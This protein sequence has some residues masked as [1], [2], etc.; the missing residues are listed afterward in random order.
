MVFQLDMFINL[1]VIADLVTI[2]D[3]GQEIINKNLRCQNLKRREWDYA[4]GQEVLIKEVDPSKLQ[5]RA[6]GPYTV[7]HVFA[8]GTVNVQRAPH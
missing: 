3:R 5:P 6:H 1:P 2:H 4:V 7:M 8:N